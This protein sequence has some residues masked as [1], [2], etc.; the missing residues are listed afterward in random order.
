M[1]S[2]IIRKTLRQVTSK[3][4]VAIKKNRQNGRSKYLPKDDVFKHLHSKAV[5]DYL[6]LQN[7]TLKKLTN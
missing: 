5:K 3:S 1:T 7:N 6:S 4:T 2:S